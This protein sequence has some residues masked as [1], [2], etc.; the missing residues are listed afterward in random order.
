MSTAKGEGARKYDAR[1]SQFGYASLSSH[2]RSTAPTLQDH[3]QVANVTI[4]L[5]YSGKK[6][7]WAALPRELPLTRDRW[8]GCC[9]E[10]PGDE[11]ETAE[12]GFDYRCRA[13]S[14][15]G[16]LGVRWGL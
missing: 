9:V 4:L 14:D 7:R 5:S 12:R 6:R 15:L 11:R 10:R 16:F 3:N 1:V 8:R 13:Q 2:D